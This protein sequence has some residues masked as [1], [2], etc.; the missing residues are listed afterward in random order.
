LSVNQHAP[1]YIISTVKRS[2]YYSRIALVLYELRSDSYNSVMVQWPPTKKQSKSFT[3]LAPQHTGITSSVK[4]T[5][6]LTLIMSKCICF[7]F[8]F[9]SFREH[10]QFET[11]IPL[12]ILI[13]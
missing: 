3:L 8:I 7:N 10:F 12:G 5:S 9:L 13:L 2:N 11:L 4:P 1:S 6:E